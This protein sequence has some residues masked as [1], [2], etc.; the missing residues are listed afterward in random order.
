MFIFSLISLVFLQ[1]VFPG[2]FSGLLDSVDTCV[3]D[4]GLT[5]CPLNVD[6]IGKPP[7]SESELNEFC[8]G[9]GCLPVKISAENFPEDD[10]CRIPPVLSKAKSTSVFGEDTKRRYLKHAKCFENIYRDFD[11][12]ETYARNKVTLFDVSSRNLQSPGD[13]NK[14]AKVC[15]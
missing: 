14:L 9:I 12:C 13:F 4:S 8:R 3:T 5:H 1:V 15:V 7:F 10:R 6:I 11:S 2:A